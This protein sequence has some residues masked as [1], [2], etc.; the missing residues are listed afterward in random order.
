MSRDMAVN[1]KGNCQRWDLPELG[2]SDIGYSGQVM[3]EEL[4]K[5]QQQA[6]QKGFERGCREG[7]DVGRQAMAEQAGHLEQLM[8]ALTRPFEDLDQKVEE[9][10]LELVFAI[11]RQLVGSEIRAN[12]EKIMTIV[13]KAVAVLPSASRNLQLHLHP[14]DAQLVHEL[15]PASDSETQWH[16]IEDIS[17][18]RGGCRVATDTSQVDASVEARLNNIIASLVEGEGDEDASE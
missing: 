2:E 4:E 5:L 15:L 14:E 13:H 1:N 9:E 16:I 10:L 7:Q 17:V 11:V 12:P 8:C 3:A 18:G 6:Y